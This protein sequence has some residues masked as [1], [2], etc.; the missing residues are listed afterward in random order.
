MT[1]AEIRAF[2]KQ[3]IEEFGE[4]YREEL[5]AE[6]ETYFTEEVR[7]AFPEI[8]LDLADPLGAI[9]R[10]YESLDAT[11]QGSVISKKTTFKRIIRAKYGNQGLGF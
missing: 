11:R 7:E 10:W 8:E 2:A 5:R 4:V 1:L 3:Q 6:F 9:D